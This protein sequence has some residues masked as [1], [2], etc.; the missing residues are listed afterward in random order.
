MG[1]P[2][3]IQRII[4]RQRFHRRGDKAE[5]ELKFF[6]GFEFFTHRHFQNSLAVLFHNTVG[7]SCGNS[8]AAS[9]FRE[10]TDAFIFHPDP[11]HRVKAEHR[12]AVLHRFCQLRPPGTALAGVQV[13]YK[14]RRQGETQ[15]QVLQVF[16]RLN[17]KLAV[18]HAVIF[19]PGIRRNA[20]ILISR[21]PLELRAIRLRAYRFRF[22]VSDR[23]AVRH[24]FTGRT[25]QFNALRL[26]P[27]WEKR[28]LIGVSASPHTVIRSIYFERSEGRQDHRFVELHFRP[29]ADS[30]KMN[31]KRRQYT[32]VA[33][34]DFRSIISRRVLPAERNRHRI[35]SHLVP[36]NLPARSIFQ[37]EGGGTVRPEFCGKQ[38][39][40]NI[41]FHLSR[42]ETRPGI[43]IH[44]VQLERNHIAGDNPVSLFQR[45]T[46]CI[47]RG[48]S[49]LC[50]QFNLPGN[51]SVELYFLF[52]DRKRLGGTVLIQ[53]CNLISCL[54]TGR[55]SDT[56]LLAERSL[57]GIVLFHDLHS[58]NI[59]AESQSDEV[60]LA[61][62]AFP[63][64][65]GGRAGIVRQTPC[66]AEVESH[67]LLRHPVQLQRLPR[68]CRLPLPYGTV[69][70]QHLDLG[71]II[72][73]PVPLH[74]V[75]FPFRI[76][77]RR[78]SGKPVQIAVDEQIQFKGFRSP[79]F[80]FRILRAQAARIDRIS[81]WN[82]IGKT[83]VQILG[84][85]RKQEFPLRCL[86]AFKR[87]SEICQYGKR[88]AIPPEC[89]R[90]LAVYD[91]RL[92]RVQRHS[93]K[94]RSSFSCRFQDHSAFFCNLLRSQHRIECPDTFYEHIVS[95][96]FRRHPP[97]AVRSQIQHGDFLHP[98]RLLIITDKLA[99]QIKTDSG[100]VPRNSRM[101]ELPVF[102]FLLHHMIDLP[103]AVAKR[104]AEVFRAFDD[105]QSGT[106]P[107]LAA[108]SQ[109]IAGIHLLPGRRQQFELEQDRALLSEQ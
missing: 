40:L 45:I 76:A 103:G 59:S 3:D 6:T 42:K 80:R 36:V 13:F 105:I 41:K 102:E 47:I 95:P 84:V 57:A 33:S 94:R 78:I 46:D 34:D 35:R 53:Q 67:R 28:I 91:R 15:L 70:D 82:M 73:F 65:Q 32:A 2:E 66:T 8:P 79:H 74:T 20:A 1:I 55:G 68:D 50:I 85:I 16:F 7:F 106:H 81:G 83:D 4:P 37:N 87:F 108:E 100:T 97:V 86:K 12:S 30:G 52:D 31:R 51:S 10:E 62:I 89:F 93:Q 54:L 75:V 43:Q 63:P 44:F 101:V 5:L 48:S 88:S 19:H 61:G 58:G 49:D 38:S 26:N 21:A 60:L 25:Q 27:A 9:R 107:R 90:E 71:T 39:G 104:E 23:S 22:S 56:Y 92:F 14:F 69:V 29:F 77:A 11:Y 18:S 24:D 99:V 17:R 64:D 96:G 72:P 98:D 109:N